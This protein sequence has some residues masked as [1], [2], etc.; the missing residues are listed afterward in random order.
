MQQ[1]TK[2]A[3]AIFIMGCLIFPVQAQGVVSVVITPS[4]VV[5]PDFVGDIFSFDF[6]VDTN[7]INATGFQT[8]ISVSGPL[9][10]T[11]TVDNDANSVAEAV[12]NDTNYW[13]YL[14]S[15]NIHPQFD[16]N[17]NFVFGDYTDNGL[18]EFLNS[19]DIVVQYAFKWNGIE[20]DYTFTLD[21]NITPPLHSFVQN[22]NYDKESLEFT[23]GSYPGN[24]NSFTVNIPEPS[25][26]IIFALGSN[27]ALLKRR[28]T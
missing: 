17:G 26:L 6:V 20:G 4:N 8:T 24:S 28:G 1:I 23:R 7:G 21:L 14:N 15:H 16:Q 27:V 19:N 13:A 22:E 12:R 25:T 11:L 3:V 2:T 9:G 10:G 18:G 5:L